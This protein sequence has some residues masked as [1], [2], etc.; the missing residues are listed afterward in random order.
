MGLLAVGS[1]ALDTVKTPFGEAKD[2]LGGSAVYFSLSAS[3]FTDVDL[4][5]VVGRDFPRPCLDILKRRRINLEGLEV[6]RGETFRWHG[7]YSYDL[8]NPQTISTHLNVF[9][10]FNPHIPG[11]Y[12]NDKFIFLA[13]IDPHL[14]RHVLRQSRSA[15]FVAADT[16]NYWIE[17]AP[18]ALKKLLKEVDAVIIN[19]TESR[20]LS[21]EWNLLKAMRG[22][23][24]LGPRVVIVKKGEHGALLYHDNSLFW[25]PAYPL[26]S[27]F[28]PTGAGDTFAGGFM[29]YLASVGKLN[30][31]TF[32]KAVIYG[33]VMASFCV[34]DFSVNR[35]KRLTKPQIEKRYREFARLTCF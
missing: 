25:A 20:E 35:I 16:M 18:A 4:V 19:E 12:R 5:G 14:Q 8:S 30:K 23:R 29:G 9:S 28:D 3:S 10:E 15:E 32:R 6:K 11:S 2:A 1:I 33:S 26:E 7:L 21:G 24:S 22:V 31:D 13:N 34:E 27:I 17:H